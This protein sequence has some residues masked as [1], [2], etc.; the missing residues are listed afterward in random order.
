[1]PPF[2]S[3]QAYELSTLTGTQVLL[4][5]ASE[6]GHVYTFA[7]PKLQPLITKQEGKN[8]IQACL[9][10]PD[11]TAIP[12]YPPSS[13]AN[14]APSHG[15]AIDLPEEDPQR[16]GSASFAAA[17]AGLAG[18]GG[19]GG[20]VSGPGT[21][22]GSHTPTPHNQ[23]G[24]SGPSAAAAAAAAAQVFMNPQAAAVQA[25]Q[26]AA[27][28]YPSNAA[29]WPGPQGPGASLYGKDH[30]H[31]SAMQSIRSQS[32]QS[33]QQ[34]QHHQQQ[35]QQQ[36]HHQQQ[37]QHQQQQM[38]QAMA[39]QQQ[40]MMHQLHQAHAQAHHYQSA[41]VSSTAGSSGRLDLM[42]SQSPSAANSDAESN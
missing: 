20:M 34:Q 2:L 23:C 41:S 21:A 17:M 39:M 1:M 36:H 10:S 22:S 25:A 38:Y 13:S 35:Q 9:N 27:F 33:Q 37:Q 19:Y 26:L 31:A 30:P 6:T 12:E 18:Y 8:L 29:F 4:L 7:T 15:D 5:V 16:S 32:G 28:P 24:T 14:Y 40:Q 11:H 3:L 42:T